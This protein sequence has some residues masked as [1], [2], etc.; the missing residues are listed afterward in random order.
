[1]RNS[2][3]VSDGL[4]EEGIGFETF[5]ALFEKSRSYDTLAKNIAKAVRACKGD[6]CYCVEGGVSE[7]RA[8]HILLEKGGAEVIEGVSRAA[9]LAAEAGLFGAYTAVSA[10]EVCEK[11]LCFPLVVY[12]L[13][14]ADLAGDLKLYLSERCG[15]EA[16]AL[17]VCE[18]GKKRIP[19]YELDRQEHYTGAGVVVY[20]V[21]LLE[22]KRFSFADCVAV[23][24]RLRAPDGCP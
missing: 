19:L 6:V 18:E 20:D 3:P 15:D 8:A 4:K 17:F 9:K 12:D 22:K 2:S 14:D 11:E 24:K 13:T 1:M 10:Y 23:L 5:D 21:P 16:E 7:D